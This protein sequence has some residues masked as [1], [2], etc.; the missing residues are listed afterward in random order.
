MAGVHAAA[1]AQC[2]HGQNGFGKVFVICAEVRPIHQLLPEY[3]RFGGDAHGHVCLPEHGRGGVCLSGVDRAFLYV[4]QAALSDG[5][6]RR[7]VFG[8]AGV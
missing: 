7:C 8:L 5:F 6:A 1:L 4:Y 2:E 3:A